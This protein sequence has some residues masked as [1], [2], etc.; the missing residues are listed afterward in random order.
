L[1]FSQSWTVLA[2]QARCFYQKKFSADPNTRAEWPFFRKRKGCKSCWPKFLPRPDFKRLVAASQSSP[3]ASL[4]TSLAYFVC[5]GLVQVKKRLIC[6]CNALDGSM[7]KTQAR[8]LFV[9]TKLFYF[10]IV[11][12]NNIRACVLFYPCHSKINQFFIYVFTRY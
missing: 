3:R 5:S 10:N 7:N 2:V 9:F 12:T 11:N 1:D 4:S 6:A 8:M